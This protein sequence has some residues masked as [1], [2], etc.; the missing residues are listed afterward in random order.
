MPLDKLCE[1]LVATVLDES[2]QRLVVLFR[3][4]CRHT[5]ASSQGFLSMGSL[6]IQ[7]YN[8][9]VKIMIF[10]PLRQRDPLR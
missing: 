3:P 2:K 9:P 4:A 6:I 7:L 5:A 1:S 10:L 8:F